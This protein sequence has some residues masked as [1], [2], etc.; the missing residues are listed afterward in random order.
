MKCVLWSYWIY[1]TLMRFNI[2]FITFHHYFSPYFIV[3]PKSKIVI[4]TSNLFGR[5]FEITN[6]QINLQLKHNTNLAPESSSFFIFTFTLFISQLSITGMETWCF[7]VLKYFPF[8]DL[9]RYFTL[10]LNI[11]KNRKQKSLVK[12]IKLINN[13]AVVFVSKFILQVLF[14]KKPIIVVLKCRMSGQSQ[15]VEQ[16]LELGW[17]IIVDFIVDLDIKAC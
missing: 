6:F 9:T 11:K 8:P 4:A 10:L 5:Q 15:E 13:S 3:W 12:L 1:A 14:L 17:K 2:F 16:N 7:F